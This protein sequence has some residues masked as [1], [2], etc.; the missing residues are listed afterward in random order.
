M[1]VK[2]L[3]EKVL[4]RKCREGVKSCGGLLVKMGLTYF[5]GFPDRLGLLQGGWCF[6]AEI[7]SEGKKPTKVQRL[8]HEKLRG[9]GFDVLIV[10]SQD[11]YLKFMEYVEQKSK[12]A[13]EGRK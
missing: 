9:L 12:V 6:F 7:K 2:K 11:S 5:L 4:E 1:G 10:D 13:G 3:G 8:V